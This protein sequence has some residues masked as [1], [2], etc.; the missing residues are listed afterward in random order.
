YDREFKRKHRCGI[1]SDKVSDL[2]SIRPVPT[3]AWRREEKV[4]EE[5][6]VRFLRLGLF[7]PDEGGIRRRKRRLPADVRHNK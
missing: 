3:A 4:R 6:L 7:I 2:S 1:E 5:R